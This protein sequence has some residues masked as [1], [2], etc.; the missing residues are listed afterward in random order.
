MRIRPLQAVVFVASFAI[1][2]IAQNPEEPVVAFAHETT[3]TLASASG[4]TVQEIKLKH[5]VYDFALSKDRKLLVT[6]APDTEHGGNL[7]LI[8]LQTH[9]QT[10]L[11]NGHVFSKA[12]DLNKGETEVY[13]DM[14]FSPDGQSLVFGIH[15][16]LPGD[17][18]DAYENS[19]PFALMNLKT[20]SIQILKSTGNIDGQGPCSEEHPMW[21]PDGKWILF[22]CED[23]AL[24]TD[25]QGKTL[26]DLKL[27]PEGDWRTGAVSWFGN[28][29]VLYSRTPEINGSLNL[30]GDEVRL[31]NLHTNQVQDPKTVFAFPNRS[32]SGLIEASDDAFIRWSNDGEKLAIET[33]ET[34]WLFPN[35]Q[36][37]RVTD[38]A[39]AHVLGGWL[40]AEIPIECK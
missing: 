19:G 14:Q 21:S 15:G 27:E 32:V 34:K 4:Q 12:K 36:Y 22:N 10:Q 37:P 6:V 8:N 3:L 13:G 29:C 5:P 16:N 24:I 40:P 33:R 11:T 20:R 31:L 39:S 25:V 23:G 18:N 17:G 26:R 28:G 9:T 38:G 1:S 7:T 30:E 2:A 35:A